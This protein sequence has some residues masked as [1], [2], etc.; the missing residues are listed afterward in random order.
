MST[1]ELAEIASF[2]CPIGREPK[3]CDGH[4]CPRRGEYP[5]DDYY[6]ECVD[7]LMAKAILRYR[8]YGKED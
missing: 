8:L 6:H 1:E 7:S 2:R 3:N 4:P 5:F